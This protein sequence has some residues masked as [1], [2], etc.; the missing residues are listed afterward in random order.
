MNLFATA[1]K[2]EKIVHLTFTSPRYL[3]AYL[4]AEDDD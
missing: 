1:L 3:Y 4:A 2:S